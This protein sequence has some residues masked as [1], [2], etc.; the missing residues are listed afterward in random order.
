MM[1]GHSVRNHKAGL[2]GRSRRL[3][4]LDCKPGQGIGKTSSGY[5]S[6]PYVL[7]ESQ[8]GMQWNPGGVLEQQTSAH[9]GYFF[10]AAG[11]CRV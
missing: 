7:P 1:G 4:A 6:N 11:F 2:N 10:V 3:G 8:G 9:K 5:S